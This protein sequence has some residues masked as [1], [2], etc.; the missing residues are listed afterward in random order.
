METQTTKSMPAV[1]HTQFATRVNV[2]SIPAEGAN[3]IIAHFFVSYYLISALGRNR[4]Y[5][6]ASAKPRP[7]R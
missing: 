7:I 4:T 1:R 5:I 2:G 6:T 3:K